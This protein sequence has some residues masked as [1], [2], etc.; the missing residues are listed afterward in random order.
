MSAPE[1][2][3]VCDHELGP[4]QP[5]ASAVSNQHEQFS[6]IRLQIA[7]AVLPLIEDSE[8]QQ[9]RTAARRSSTK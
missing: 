7:S 1:N 6:L 4:F 9:E 5:Q 3:L 2:Q 8:A